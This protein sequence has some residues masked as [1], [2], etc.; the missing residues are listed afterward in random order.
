M[1]PAPVL[2]ANLFMK[3]VAFLVQV[4]YLPFYHLWWQIFSGVVSVQWTYN[5]WW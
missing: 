4:W 2:E 3:W 5:V 1:T